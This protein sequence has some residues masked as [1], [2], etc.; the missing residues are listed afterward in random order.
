LFTVGETSFVLFDLFHGAIL[1]L[2]F[3]AAVSMAFCKPTVE[4]ICPTTTAF[5]LRKPRNLV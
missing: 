2:V 4:L 1:I 3:L 5:Y